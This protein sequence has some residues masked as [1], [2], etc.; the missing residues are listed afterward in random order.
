MEKL[1]LILKFKLSWPQTLGKNPGLSQ[2]AS[3]DLIRFLIF[4]SSS[5]VQLT[6]LGKDQLYQLETN[7]TNPEGRKED[8]LNNFFTQGSFLWFVFQQL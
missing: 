3:T 4:W 8:F 1:I 2:A 5:Q 7:F 6:H